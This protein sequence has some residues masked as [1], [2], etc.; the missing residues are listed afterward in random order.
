MTPTAHVLRQLA[1][2]EQS[3]WCDLCARRLRGASSFA[4][5][6]THPISSLYSFQHRIMLISCAVLLVLN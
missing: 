1:G 3:R 2:N 6:A 5:G 4:V